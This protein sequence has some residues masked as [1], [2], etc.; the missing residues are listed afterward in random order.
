MRS[1]IIALLSRFFVRLRYPWLFAIAAS[2]FLLD[3]L[4]PDFIPLID[5]VLLAVVTILLASRKAERE[6][7]AGEEAPSGP[8]SDDPPI[9]DITPK[10]QS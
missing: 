5:E 10:D 6:P 1:P 2:L 9:I 8:P 7:S 4:I 3:M